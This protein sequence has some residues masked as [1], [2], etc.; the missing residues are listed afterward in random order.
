MGGSS[1][2]KS[3]HVDSITE[4]LEGRQFRGGKW[5]GLGDKRLGQLVESTVW[6]PIHIWPV[7]KTDQI[8]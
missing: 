7:L 1:H 4:E 3:V 5:V 6:V 2:E 8:V